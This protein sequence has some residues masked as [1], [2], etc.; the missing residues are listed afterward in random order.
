MSA[1]YNRLVHDIVRKRKPGGFRLG[2][3]PL[4]YG[5]WLALAVGCAVL[6]QGMRWATTHRLTGECCMAELAHSYVYTVKSKWRPACSAFAHLP[7]E[8]FHA[9]NGYPLT[10]H[11]QYA[12]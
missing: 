10:L 8:A 9:I 2:E 12:R 4:T 6:L 11:P 3:N 7:I 5:L 1:P